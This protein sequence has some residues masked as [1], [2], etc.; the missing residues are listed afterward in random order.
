M[1]PVKILLAWSFAQCRVGLVHI[2]AVSVSVGVDTVLLVAGSGVGVAFSGCSLP[3]L[4]RMFL[5]LLN[6]LLLSHSNGL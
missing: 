5:A 6:R 2:G 1:L 4:G 3:N